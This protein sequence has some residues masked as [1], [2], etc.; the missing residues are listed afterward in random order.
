MAQLGIDRPSTHRIGGHFRCREHSLRIR[1]TYLCPGC[2]VAP[3]ERGSSHM[4]HLSASKLTFSP[5]WDDMSED[6]RA[7]E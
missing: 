1:G 6:E 7:A 4:A 2:R 3:G 5:K